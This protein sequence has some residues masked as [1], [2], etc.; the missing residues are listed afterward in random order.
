MVEATRH[1]DSR[2]RHTVIDTLIKRGRL[3]PNMRHKYGDFGYEVLI[4]DC[5]ETLKSLPADSVDCCITSPPYFNL[6][7]Y[8]TGTWDG[9][10]D[11]DCDHKIPSSELDGK[12]TGEDLGSSHTIRFNRESCYKCGAKRK[13]K[14]I[15]LEDTFADYIESMVGVMQEVRRVLKPTGTLWLNIGDSYN[16]SGG[17]GGDYAKGG[18][19]EGQPKYGGHNDKNLKKKD[20]MMIPARLAIALQEDGWYLRSDI[21]WNKSNPM[22]ESVKDRPTQTHEHIF[23][24]S[25]CPHYYYDGDAIKEPAAQNRWG[26]KTPMNLD[27]VKGQVR[28]LSR[29]R[30]MMPET[31]NKRNVW[32]VNTKPFKG[33]HFA[34]FP[35]ELIEP[36]VLAGSP[37]SGVVLDPFGGSGTTAGVAIKHGRN[38]ILCELNEDYAA[39]IPKRVETI[40]GFAETGDV[41]WI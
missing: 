30:D 40:V 5:L 12:R 37:P 31:R 3:S 1:T 11:P 28:G 19:K 22:P 35:P 6:R 25:K 21:I 27:N 17:A 13:D 34:V 32:T 14:Q 20:L 7:D 18:L 26:K 10:N 16:G 4:G 33:A 8:Q 9:G 38:A 36:C 24:M 2:A 15:G 39:L 41:S 23:L 29:E